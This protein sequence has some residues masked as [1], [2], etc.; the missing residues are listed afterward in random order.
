MTLDI[1]TIGNLEK[2]FLKKRQAI[3]AES[4]AD[5]VMLLNTDISVSNYKR[6]LPLFKDPKLFAVTF[7]P[8]SSQTGKIRRVDYANGGS[9][10][11]RRKIWNRIGGIDL[12][13]EPFWF[14]DT[15]YSRRATSAGYYILEDGRIKVIQVSPL[16]TGVIKKS[17]MG[18]L[19]YWRNFFLY[20]RKHN[21]PPGRK[22]LLFPVF[23]PF[24]IWANIRYQKYHG[25]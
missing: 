10:I 17:L 1:F 20:H 15:D 13:F 22:H 11:Y 24:I 21:I 4:R 19:I 6:S 25:Q 18:I 16:G 14:D 9:S 5:L 23:W 12:M 2:D 3:M 7:S 8:Q